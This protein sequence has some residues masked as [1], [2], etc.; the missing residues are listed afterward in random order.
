MD[1]CQFA[2]RTRDSGLKWRGA[3]IRLGGRLTQFPRGAPVMRPSAGHQ[4][5]APR[6]FACVRHRCLD[7]ADLY[8][9]TIDFGGHP[10][11]RSVTGNMTM[12]DEPGKRTM[13][14]I[15]QH[16]DGIE[17]DFVLKS[18]A[19]CGMTSLEMLQVVFNT[20]F[21]LLG[22]NAAMLELWKGL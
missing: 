7:L 14:T 9:R 6:R 8:Q 10:N 3:S 2:A 15:M 16:G 17:L 20:R 12:V 18:V 22:I 1:D 5:S 13:L 11:E 4:S 19:Q 21:E